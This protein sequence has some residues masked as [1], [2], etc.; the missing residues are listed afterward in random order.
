M[1][2]I[3][4]CDSTGLH[5][6]IIARWQQGGWEEGSRELVGV[7][8][9][10]RYRTGVLLT[11]RRSKLCHWEV[12]GDDLALLKCPPELAERMLE[13]RDRF[14]EQEKLDAQARAGENEERIKRDREI[15]AR[16]ELDRRQEELKARD[17]AELAEAQ[18]W[19]RIAQLVIEMLQADP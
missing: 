4:F 19:A 10:S 16:L 14:R 17:A 6:D 2:P 7:E 5:W 11:W 13:L 12:S 15:Q 8:A 18:R 9:Q 1:S 3:S